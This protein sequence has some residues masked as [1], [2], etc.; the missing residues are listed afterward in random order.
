MS[1]KKKLKQKNKININKNNLK[2]AKGYLLSV[3]RF[4]Y[5]RSNDG[6]Y[7]NM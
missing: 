3:P 6:N 5:E 4:H 1:S 2:P 7:T